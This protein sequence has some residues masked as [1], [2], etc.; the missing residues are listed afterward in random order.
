MFVLN[1]ISLM[2]H[3]ITWWL[4]NGA[5]IHA[6]NSMQVVISKR[7]PTSFKQYVYMGD[8]IESKFIL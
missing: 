5:T 3:L 6:Y 8:G 1:I 7:S 2:C 4:D